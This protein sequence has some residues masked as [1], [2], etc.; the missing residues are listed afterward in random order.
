MNFEEWAPYYEKILTEFGFS[1]ERDEMSATYLSAYSL[2]NFGP[3]L[4]NLDQIRGRN[5]LICGNAPALESELLSFFSK[6]ENNPDFFSSPI[7][8]AADGAASVLMQF[9]QP[10]IIVTDLDGKR[11]RD[12]E[13]EI[14]CFA[15]GATILV[16]AHGDNRDK[17]EKYLPQF[18]K[19]T[20][21][22]IPTCQC[23]PPRNIYNFG[24]FTDG[25]RCIFLAD[26]FGA[27]NILL[28]GF[29]FND[30]QV[31]DFKKKKLGCAK[32]LIQKVNQK[33]INRG[34]SEILFFKK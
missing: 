25:D 20:G 23:R 18:K 29:D 19:G 1:K 28:L 24:G 30:Q 34:D 17:L 31:T 32:K 8:I 13:N 16:H 33:R 2:Q 21:F 27:R 22:F 15:S 3:A 12:A 14:S 11:E 26:A 5:V 9:R 10:D 7:F 4:L 6:S